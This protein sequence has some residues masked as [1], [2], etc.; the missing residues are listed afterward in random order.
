MS[1]IEKS[2]DEALDEALEKI[3]D[4]LIQGG[5]LGE[6]PEGYSV[7]S[8]CQLLCKPI[9]QECIN[10]VVIEHCSRGGWVRNAKKYFNHLT[11][12]ESGV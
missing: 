4:L 6:I 2:L 11:S 5:G 12:T 8:F 1:E 7:E 9:L 3:G 10:K